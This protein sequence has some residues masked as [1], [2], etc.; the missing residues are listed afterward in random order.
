MRSISL[1]TLIRVGSTLALALFCAGCSDMNF[2]WFGKKDPPPEKPPA[3]AEA[4]D[5]VLGEMIGAR[6]LYSNAEP[7]Q[8]RGFGL[9]R[10]LGEN[11]SN[12]CPTTI[13]D[14][15]VD[16]LTKELTI[17]DGRKV[18]PAFSPAK[19]IDSL[20]TAVVSVR[21][22]VQPGAPK[23]SVFDVEIEAIG[24]QTRS[25]EGGFLLLTELKLFNSTDAGRAMI[26][27]RALSKA[28]GPVYTDPRA[29]GI[30]PETGSGP[31]TG[32][33]LGGG[34][35]LE[36]RSL[37]MLLHE[38]SYSMARRIERR[39]NERFGHNPPAAE[40]VS[41]GYVE[42]HTPAAYA[43]E[44]DHFLQLVS[45]LFLDNTPAYVERKLRELDEETTDDEDRMRRI[46]LAWEGF[47]R[48]SLPHAQALYARPEPAIAFHSARAGL[49]LRDV[50]AIAVMGRLTADDSPKRMDAI[51]ELG[52][53][54]MPQAAQ[55]LVPLLNAADNE[56]R[57]AAYDALRNYPTPVVSSR[58]LRSA[59]D[60]RFSN[61]KLD[62]VESSGEPLIYVRQAREPRIA[63]F[64]PRATLETPLFYEHPAELLTLNA[65][66]D[67]SDV[68]MFCHTRQH[69]KLSDPV[70]TPPRIADVIRGMGDLPI[71]DS[72][73]K[74][75]G[76][77]Q[78]YSLV[79]EVLE[80]LRSREAL[81][82]A[83]VMETN[84]L[85]DQLGGSS[86]PERNEAD[87]EITLTPKSRE[88]ADAPPDDGFDRSDRAPE[89]KEAKRDAA[90]AREE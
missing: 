45:H 41:R 69:G 68:T 28:M 29:A 6:A 38:P 18:K 47:G 14:Y 77:G 78:C 24:N 17:E 1:N 85:R 72:S 83:L 65:I 84:N 54:R 19:L 55:Q 22:F 63:I 60:Q 58:D 21:G 74:F 62:L 23:N 9:V 86:V 59:L 51:R 90:P 53:C 40:A 5:S 20:D 70:V 81:S 67:H 35:T 36:N 48:V 79:V 88:E 32:F 80:G 33:V 76:L 57:I 30:N 25:L 39:V 2:D 16:F 73:G 49:R 56:T 7:L 64:G 61:F 13:R 42:L 10:G 15:L 37:R 75:R 27:G 44:P 34:F 26:A 43:D 66:E 12:D 11:G 71:K 31:R 82:A 3:T 4:G 50:G 87:E 52:R 8:L 46:S 89:R